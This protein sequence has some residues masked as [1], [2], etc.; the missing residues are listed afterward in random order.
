MQKPPTGVVKSYV[1]DKYA[2]NQAVPHTAVI[3]A[4]TEGGRLDRIDVVDA[5]GTVDAVLYVGT[6]TAYNELIDGKALNKLTYNFGTAEVGPIS[7][8]GLIRRGEPVRIYIAAGNGAGTYRLK[9]T[10]RN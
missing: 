10:Y 2:A 8:S 9:F 7:N 3:P 5:T 1:T 6:K 4:T